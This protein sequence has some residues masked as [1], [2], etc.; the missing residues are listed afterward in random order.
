MW[1]LYENNLLLNSFFKKL[2]YVIIKRVLE[3]GNEMKVYATVSVC[4]KI[5]FDV[6]ENL[7]SSYQHLFN[8]IASD[9]EWDAIDDFQWQEAKKFVLPNEELYSFDVINVE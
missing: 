7:I 1:R 5:E 9:E 8:N 3:K 2:Y 6:P 4:R